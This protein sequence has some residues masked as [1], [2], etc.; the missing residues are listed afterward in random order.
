MTRKM[1]IQYYPDTRPVN[2]V[3]YY[4]A[5]AINAMHEKQKQE[6]EHACNAN[7][8]MM[9]ITANAILAKYGRK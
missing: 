4:S 2:T 3:K 9:E 7:R 5:E 8:A 1:T 6:Q